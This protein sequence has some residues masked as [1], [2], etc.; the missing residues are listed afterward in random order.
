MCSEM[1]GGQGL[2]RAQGK[3]SAVAHNASR[4]R[5]SRQSHKYFSV[6]CKQ[7][8]TSVSVDPHNTIPLFNETCDDLDAYLKRFEWVAT[9]QGWPKE[10]WA[11]A[12]S[13]CLNGE[14]LRVFGHLSLED[15]LDYD[16]TKLALLHCFMF[17]VDGYHEKFRHNKPQD[18]EIGKQYAAR[19]FSL[20]DLWVELCNEER[21]LMWFAT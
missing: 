2:S 4:D 1:W 10:K 19:L 5:W 8:A 11:T 14:A 16:K 12:L 9:R 3:D 18:G 13:L 7:P 15:S 21:L 6:A 20:F 17:T